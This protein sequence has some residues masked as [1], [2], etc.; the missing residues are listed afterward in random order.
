MFLGIIRTD[1]SATMYD[2]EIKYQN[3]MKNIPLNRLGLADE[4]AGAVA[5]LVSQLF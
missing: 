5:F 2:D 4:C 3:L 1:F